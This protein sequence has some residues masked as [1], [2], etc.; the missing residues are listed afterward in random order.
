MLSIARRVLF[1]GHEEIAT[2]DLIDL[3]YTDTLRGFRK[4]RQH[5]EID[6]HF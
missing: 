2:L 1:L 4:N 6:Y 3:L 5:A